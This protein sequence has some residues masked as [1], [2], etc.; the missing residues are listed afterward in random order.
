M[1]PEL[2]VTARRL[3]PFAIALVCIG[4][5]V[6]FGGGGWLLWIELSGKAAGDG[7]ISR[8]IWQV[9]AEQPWVVLIIVVVVHMLVDIGLV[10]IAFLLGH[11]TAQ[12]DE[13][14]QAI[15]EGRR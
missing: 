6:I 7:T 14:Y 9:W 13:V 15:R 5:L 11:F 12:S 3:L 4:L 1:K 2:V 8:L 10:V